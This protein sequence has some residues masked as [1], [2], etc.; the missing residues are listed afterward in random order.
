MGLCCLTTS[1]DSQRG[2]T[3]TKTRI[4]SRKDAKEEHC[5]FEPFEGLRINSERN[6]S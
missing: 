3:A 2:E 6:L 1:T 5:H 4:I